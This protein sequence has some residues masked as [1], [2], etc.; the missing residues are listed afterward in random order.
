MVR[1]ILLAA[2][3]GQGERRCQP[4]RDATHHAANGM[5]PREMLF[6]VLHRS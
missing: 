6:D 3:R 5:A 1:E 4:I 2:A